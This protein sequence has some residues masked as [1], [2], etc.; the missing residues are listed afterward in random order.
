M[1]QPVIVV[2]TFG[3]INEFFKQNCRNL[4]IGRIFEALLCV[5]ICAQVTGLRSVQF[6]ALYLWLNELFTSPFTGRTDQTVWVIHSWNRRVV[7][8][9]R[10]HVSV[11]CCCRRTLAEQ[12][13]DNFRNWMFTTRYFYALL[14]FSS[15]DWSCQTERKTLEVWTQLN[16]SLDLCEYPVE[17]TTNVG[18]ERGSVSSWPWFSVLH[19]Y[20]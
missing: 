8:R 13:D 1:N 4:C 6:F 16:I 12:G 2:T 15:Y 19:H 5:Y 10:S 3:K 11:L 9:T 7:L 14:T 20:R 17:I 18:R